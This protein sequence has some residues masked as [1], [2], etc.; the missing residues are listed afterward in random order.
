MTILEINCNV[1]FIREN[2]RRISLDVGE[3][4]KSRDSSFQFKIFKNLTFKYR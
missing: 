1:F 4:K 3:L 2:T